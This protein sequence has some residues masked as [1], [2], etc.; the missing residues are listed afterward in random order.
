MPLT[1]VQKSADFLSAVLKKEPNLFD[2]LGALETAKK[3]EL[4]ELLDHE[5]YIVWINLYNA[6]TQME[7][8]LMEGDKVQKQMFTEEIFTVAGQ[9]I[10][11]DIIEHGILRGNKWKYSLGFLN[12]GHL[13]P[14]IRH[15]KCKRPDPRVHFVLNCGAA[16]CPII[17]VLTYKN[18]E[19]EFE[20]AEKD[21]ILQETQV[22]HDK[23][24]IRVPGLFLFYFADFGRSKGIR[25]RVSAFIDHPNYKL[26]Y[27]KFDW[28]TQAYKV[29]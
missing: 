26:K 16:S 19:I 25:K 12:G 4:T 28:T 20:E 23:K 22:D 9:S 21:Y 17:R 5:K 1:I 18:L 14:R 10:S 11:L 2:H 3:E 7:L 15:W 13:P 27:Q 6:F 29:K 24:Q 8:R